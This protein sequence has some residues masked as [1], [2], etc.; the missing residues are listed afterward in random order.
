[1]LNQKIQKLDKIL[2]GVNAEYNLLSSQVKLA[3]ENLKSASR[4]KMD[5]VTSQQSL[6]SSLAELK[7]ET[8]TTLRSVKEKVKEKEDKLV[9]SDILQLEVK[10]LRDILTMRSDEVYGL[11]NRNEQLQ[12]SIEERKHE[13]EVHKETLQAQLKILLEDIHRVTLEKKE[14]EMRIEKL[15]SK[16]EVTKGRVQGAGG[17]DGEEKSQAYFV[18]EA[19]QEREEL[20][21]EGDGLDAEIAKA[22]KEVPALENTLQKLLGKNAAYRTSFRRV[23]QRKIT[24]VTTS[25][26]EK[27]DR[28]YDRMKSKRAEERQL[29]ADVDQAETRVDT[30]QDDI[31][32]KLSHVS[33]VREEMA[34]VEGEMAELGDRLAR[35]LKRLEVTAGQLSGSGTPLAMQKEVALKEI[36]E[37]NLSALQELRN[38]SSLHPKSGIID[39]ISQAGIRI[40]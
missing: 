21:R 4:T 36:E 27:L 19:A 2:E 15:Q 11:E 26:R 22:E 32:H 30:I 37:L 35:S 20:Q 25:L 17:D 34:G 14:K 5:F 38:L 24:E 7:L 18:I 40:T 39:K 29:Q 31:K 23:D 9:A 3:E 13:V 33:V 28:S 8:E 10:R 6:E 12:M 1:M 16:F